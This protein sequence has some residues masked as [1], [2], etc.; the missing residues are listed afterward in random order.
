MRDN[1]SPLERQALRTLRRRQD[2]VI[3]P[4]DKGSAVVVWSKKDYI[5]EAERQLGNENHYRKLEKDPTSTYTAEI[6]NV[7]QKMYSNGAIEKN[8]KN[9]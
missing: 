3:K 1:L 2:I 8:V 7:V 4:A 6:K 5:K 9:F